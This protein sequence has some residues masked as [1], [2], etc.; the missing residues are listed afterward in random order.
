VLR[1][2]EREALRAELVWRAEDWKW[3]SRPGRRRD[4]P[5]L[6]NGEEP[7]RDEWWRERVNEPLSGG[8]PQ[9]LR[10]SMSRGRPNGQDALTRE[11][12]KRL[13]LACCLRPQGRPRK[14]DV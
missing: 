13:G 4:D 5:S 1:Y 12:T 3:S 10:Y 8:D 2:V 6:T 7:V 14:E 9:R 11:T